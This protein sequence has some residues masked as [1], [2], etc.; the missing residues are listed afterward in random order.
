MDVV[1]EWQAVNETFT[2]YS[3]EETGGGEIDRFSDKLH[4][5]AIIN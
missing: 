5:R 2:L 3:V 1:W 4:W